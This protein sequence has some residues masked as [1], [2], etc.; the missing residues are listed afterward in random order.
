MPALVDG[1][2]VYTDDELAAAAV[3]NED[4]D[5]AR[6]AQARIDALSADTAL[7]TK[8]AVYKAQVNAAEIATLAEIIN[9]KDPADEAVT[10]VPAS[11]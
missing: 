2:V 10:D 8:L 5:P 7:H 11:S 1:K 3:A 9:R 4:S 6:K